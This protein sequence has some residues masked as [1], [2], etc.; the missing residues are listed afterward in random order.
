M[1]FLLSI[2]VQPNASK[3]EIV[4]EHNGM[5]KI[6]IKAPVD[7]GKANKELIA[8]LAKH[9]NFKKNQVTIIKGHISRQK[10]VE[11]DVDEMPVDLEELLASIQ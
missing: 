4:G 7:S 1:S 11:L 3:N 2:Y 10:I 9:F 5:L 8:F 6:K